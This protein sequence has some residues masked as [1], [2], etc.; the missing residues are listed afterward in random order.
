MLAVALGASGEVREVSFSE[1]ALGLIL[2]PRNVVVG[3][4]SGTVA[5]TMVVGFTRNPD[6]GAGQAQRSERVRMHDVVVTAAGEDVSGVAFEEL[7][8]RLRAL[9]RPLRL[10]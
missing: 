9:P 5:Q 10:R 1:G 3:S 7:L 2:E 6:G 4:G 8:A